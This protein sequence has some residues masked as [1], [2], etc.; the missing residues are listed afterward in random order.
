M[1]TPVTTPEIRARLPR[2]ENATRFWWV[3]HAHVPEV[4]THMYG[5]L[6]VDCDTSDTALFEGVAARLPDD[7][8]WV[9]STLRR[10][11]QTAD[12]LI[13]AGARPGDR[14]EDADIAELDFGD[15]NGMELQELFALR[16]DPFLGFW[17]LS[18]HE[19]A[20]NG[21]SFTMLAARVRRFVETMQRER[22]GRDVVCVSHRGTILAALQIALELPLTTSVAFDIG[23]VSLTRLVHHADVPEGGPFYRVGEVGWLPHGRSTA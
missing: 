2:P 12:A 11:R 18:P 17:P 19:Q 20:P 1:Q 4:G 15:Y 21:E 7:A 14:R 22:A 8:L 23:N 3:R 6:D 5:S 13:A 16:R 10:T 9:N